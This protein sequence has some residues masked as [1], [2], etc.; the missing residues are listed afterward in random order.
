MIAF[1]DARESG[2]N[3]M[4]SKKKYLDGQSLCKDVIELLFGHLDRRLRCIAAADRD[5]IPGLVY[6]S[7]TVFIADLDLPGMTVRI[8][9]KNNNGIS[10]S[11]SSQPK[12][13]QQQ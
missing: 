11:A 8:R 4:E 1:M 12:G 5:R 2:F 3:S 10:G 7:G 9:Q 6:A 13:T